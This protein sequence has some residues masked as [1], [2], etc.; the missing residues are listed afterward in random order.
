MRRLLLAFFLVLVLA[1]PA[2]AQE[3][4]VALIVGADRYRHI[5]AL[6]N[7]VNDARAVSA[8]L[9]A[10]GFEVIGPVLD[11]TRE[12]FNAALDRF[13]QRL[14]GAEAGLFFFAGHAVEVDGRNHLLPVDAPA[15]QSRR[16]LEGAS[17]Q[18]SDIV[19]E[20]Q[21]RTP[22]VI[23]LLDACRDNPLPRDAAR[24]GTPVLGSRGGLRGLEPI[25]G[26]PA[27]GGRFVVF[28]AEPGEVALDR[29]PTDRPNANGL[30]TRYLLRALDEPARPINV[31]MS[32]V[33]DQVAL[34]AQQAGRSQRPHI[35]DRM[36]G[37]GQFMLARAVAPA[38]LPVQTSPQTAP[39][40]LDLAFWQSIQH[41][42]SMADFEAY[43]REFPRGRFVA[44]A[45]NR[46]SAM[47]EDQALWERV[48]N[49]RNPTDVERYLAE[50]PQGAFVIQAR[51]R[52]AEL[53]A[54][55]AAA[56]VQP[57][58]LPVPTAAAIRALTREETVGAQ[59]FLNALGFDT[60][61]ATG[62]IGPRSRAAM[63]SFAQVALRPDQT[64][65]DTAN[66]QRLEALHRDFLRLTERGAISPRG[67]PAAS[68]GG[69]EARFLRGWNAQQANPA[70]HTE[71]AY[72]Y[73]LAALEH[74][75]RA[76]NQLGLLMV[77]GQGVTQDAAGG[78]LLWRL[79]AARRDATAAFNLGAMLER[80]IGVNR[81]PG[82]A[83]FYYDLALQNGHPEAREA[84]RRVG[85]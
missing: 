63:E 46:L 7:A 22:R 48:Q 70:D 40:A 58:A 24:G 1:P 59:R 82:W 6:T 81:N 54:P 74:E 50:F 41:S 27:G 26:A 52:L 38:S 17:L 14:S 25:Q 68:V 36:V 51:A 62:A 13:E 3:R 73:A 60:G 77:R 72:W 23:I 53:R 55:P 11:P 78:S 64:E 84:L 79:A 67:V 49:S 19:N 61:G 28:A 76:L 83:R 37:S 56:P 8:R 15:A 57:A 32:D 66:L 2:L 44:L 16:Q 35:D 69:A 5:P 65:F 30:F 80:G 12:Q 4:R 39:E 42:R 31:L 47:R 18:L 9:A 20:M 71:A 45:R 43:L 29:L 34:A 33:R 85:P 75:T 21:A 10:L